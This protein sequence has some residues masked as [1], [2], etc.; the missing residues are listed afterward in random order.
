MN[1]FY[2]VAAAVPELRV[3]DP[4]YNV[5]RML[6]C[7]REASENGAA[8][9]VFPELGITGASCGDM[10]AQTALI[11]TA[12]AELKAF[13]AATSGSGML[14]IVGVPVRI[15]S[16]L[17][18]AAAVI[19]N[20]V[21]L[22]FSLKEYLS[23]A[24]DSGEKRL[25][26]SVREFRGDSIVFDACD[27]PAGS[28]LVFCTANG[29]RF[30]VEI[31]AD[32]WTV[33]P[34]SSNLAIGGA[35]VVFNL[36]ADY[37]CV[38]RA[39]FRRNLVVNQSARLSGVYVLAGAGVHESTTDGVCSGHAVIAEN[40]RLVVENTRFTRAATLIFADIKP[41]WV[42]SRR[43]VRSTFNDSVEVRRIRRVAAPAWIASPDLHYATLSAH[44]FV[45][46]DAAVLAAR[47]NEI[48]NIQVAGLAKRIEHTGLKRLIIGVSGGLDS[49]LALLVCARMCD[50]LQLPRS[51]ILGVTLPGF[52]TSARTKG[53]AQKL[54]EALGAEL[55]VIHIGSAVNR[56]FKDIGHDPDNHNIVFE[57]AQARERTQIL[58]DLANAESGLLVGTG[59]LSEQAL[60]W[61]T[62]NGD[63]MS[64]YNVN[65]SIPK[66]LIRHLLSF[67]AS[68]AEPK[69]A[70]VLVDINKT[71]VS[72]ELLPGEQRTEDVLGQYAL[73]DF[74]L[75][76]FIKFGETPESLVAL[77]Q[78]AFAKAVS[79]KEIRQTLA[80]FLS[81]FVS[82]QFK[83]NA[84]P[85]GP[86]VG[87]IGLSPRGD[88]R[89]P[90]DLSDAVWQM[91]ATRG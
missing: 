14:A 90:S 64:M 34:P 48:F 75:Y 71:P 56:H 32:L 79:E 77:A 91:G 66:T 84:V 55:R 62:F 47:C 59:D 81:R 87:S 18:N 20:G 27:V 19:A 70:S 4:V 39:D 85:D 72:P 30:G 50:L 44:P 15:E 43:S 88:W 68:D 80:I 36:S 25:F 28:G 78:E 53:N 23:N 63:H 69:L 41:D 3:G 21:L 6:A 2:R 26:C 11:E 12:E 24:R 13:V 54:L 89:C 51:F 31:G 5:A 35:Q 67:V 42:D 1:G 83:R 22:G 60:G 9:V 7:Y 52:G 37:E 45:P 29:V 33:I 38:G 61:C 49:T 73:H 58:M 76:Y 46:A 57:N 16:R 8:V 40:G 10:F 17:F 65:A 74:F 86:K 82:Q